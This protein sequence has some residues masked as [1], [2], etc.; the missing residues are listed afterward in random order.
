MSVL[1]TAGFWTAT[2]ER[3]IKTAAQAFVGSIGVTAVL[4][5]IN[6][7][8]VGGVTAVAAI[9]SVGTSLASAPIGGTNGPSLGPE[10]VVEKDH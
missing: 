3:A 1:A 7:E 4:S 5:E 2:L 10:V 8:V 6:W 9:L